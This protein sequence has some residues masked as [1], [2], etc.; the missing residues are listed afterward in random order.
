MGGTK[1][2]VAEVA[3]EIVGTVATINRE[4]ALADGSVIP[5]AYICDAK[6]VAAYRGRTVLGRLLTR[7]RDEIFASG[8]HCAYSIVMSGSTPSDQFTGRLGIP[9]FEQLGDLA[10]LRFDTHTRS[11]WEKQP[12]ENVLQDYR[13][14][15]G[16]DASICSEINPIP[17]VVQ[18]ARGKLVDTRMGK[19]L[20]RSDGHELVSGHLI[21]LQFDSIGSFTTL[22]DAAKIK[23]AECGFPGLFLALPA[24]SR[25]LETIPKDLLQ[26]QVTRAEA[27]IYG[28]GIPAGEW[29]TNTSEI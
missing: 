16:G 6:V 5:V 8:C 19:R 4:I 3:E 10:I 27:R 28:V 13:R 12:C 11:A 2:Y 9:R 23:A 26:T 20:W 24:S 1:I 25:F 29:M 22:I 17:V 15:E 18:G 21:D 7:A 14:I